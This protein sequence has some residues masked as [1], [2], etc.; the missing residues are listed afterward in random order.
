MPIL[1]TFLYLSFTV[2]TFGT[3]ANEPIGTLDSSHRLTLP[4]AP[5]E[6]SGFLIPEPPAEEVDVPDSNS[7]A[8]SENRSF[9]DDLGLK[10]DGLDDQLW[11]YLTRKEVDT[12][13]SLLPQHP[14]ESALKYFLITMLH[15]KAAAPRH[16]TDG[17]LETRVN[18]LVHLGAFSDATALIEAVPASLRPAPLKRMYAEL[19]FKTGRGEE[20]CH[21]YRTLFET[22]ENP[23]PAM[24]RMVIFCLA[25]L[26]HGDQ[27]ELA[28]SI[29]RE[30]SDAM[31]AWFDS[32]MD[33][34]RYENIKI[35]PPESPLT[36]MSD[37][38][39]WFDRAGKALDAD[40]RLETRTA[41][42]L[43]IVAHN[44]HYELSVRTTFMEQAVNRGMAPIEALLPLY[45]QLRQT[46]RKGRIQEVHRRATLYH[47]LQNK[48]IAT[49][50]QKPSVYTTGVLLASFEK[51]G[52]HYTAHR[53]LEP[54]YRTIATAYENSLPENR[55]AAQALAA[56]TGNP[57]NAA[58]KPWL[59]MLDRFYTNDPLTFIA[60]SIQPVLMQTN[61]PASEAA[62]SLPS[63]TVTDSLSDNAALQLAQ[64]Y[65]AMRAFGYRVNDDALQAV[66]QA[67][68]D[69]SSDESN[70]LLQAG[71]EGNLAK[72]ILLLMSFAENGKL[73]T[74]S[75]AT[76]ET[77]ITVLQRF[78]Q[79]ELARQLAIEVI[80]S[81]TP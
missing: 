37:R 67:N 10:S 14:P 6:E 57:D 81:H 28:R 24:Q 45:D 72:V 47:K 40:S 73:S 50:N 22:T 78:N 38:L 35:T 21:L 63:F 75:P 60:Y 71:R 70:D 31:P 55:F 76:L 44:P 39:V 58:L 4:P 49:A 8:I 56:L 9:I 32:I 41:D 53:L 69:T 7:I 36:N 12:L 5:A 19:L 64:F 54:L 18:A 42:Y 46:K 33:D 34:F 52:L 11:R 80:F 61:L 77:A 74:L 13:L 65:H 66:S 1:S 2:S 30:K 59:R 23:S 48:L 25:R 51:E 20:A 15:H 17:W 43:L 62:R 16:N 3:Q 26:E 29:L 79:H 68:T 27:A